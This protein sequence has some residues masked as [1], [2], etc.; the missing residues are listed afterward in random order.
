MKPGDVARLLVMGA[1][2]ALG[3][4]S[5]V[6]QQQQQQGQPPGGAAQPG[7]PGGG[8]SAC[9]PA[10]D[11]YFMCAGLAADEQQRSECI[12][13]CEQQQFDPQQLAVY[14]TLDC[15]T[16]LEVVHGNGG[17]F[18]GGGAGGEAPAGACNADCHGCVWDGSTCYYHA[19]SGAGIVSECAACCCAEG[20]PAKRW[21]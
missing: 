17:G 21:D 18:G 1:A 10:C 3:A 12:Y 14:P 6:Q 4:A 19:A 8:E 7:A 9:A 15:A 20:G 16:A 13:S 5:A 2:V 11:H